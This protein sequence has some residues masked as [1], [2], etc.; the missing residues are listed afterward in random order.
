ME[1]EENFIL[2]FITLEFYTKVSA[3]DPITLVEVVSI[4]PSSL[5]RELQK[6]FIINKLRRKINS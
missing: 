1:E 3:M 4:L 6:K 5:D 2:E